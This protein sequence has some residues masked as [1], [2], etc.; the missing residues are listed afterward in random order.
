MIESSPGA[1]YIATMDTE[2]A[3]ITGRDFLISC[4][5]G[6]MGIIF[7]TA[8]TQRNLTYDG[9]AF[10]AH[11]GESPR[12]AHLHHPMLGY[13]LFAFVRVGAMVSVAPV[14]AGQLFAAVFGGLAIAAFHALLLRHAVTRLCA[15]IYAAL[16]GL[17]MIVMEN[18][19]S[20]ELYTP[21]LVAIVLSLHAVRSV[22]LSPTGW[23]R[24]LVWL[25]CMA[26][27][28]MHVGFSLWVFAIYVALAIESRNWL[29]GTVW[30]LHGA[31]VLA[32]L[33]LWL[34]LEGHL[35]HGVFEEREGFFQTFGRLDSTA[36]ALLI[37]LETPLMYFGRYAG[38]TIFPAAIGLA[39]FWR[40]R[41]VEFSLAVI[42]TFILWIVF[43]FWACDY[44]SFFI[45]LLP[46]WGLAS[47]LTVDALMRRWGRRC[48]MLLI[49][50][51]FVHAYVFM[52]LPMQYPDEIEFEGI[53]VLFAVGFWVVGAALV[54]LSKKVLSTTE[55]NG[56]ADAGRHTRPLLHFGFSAVM[57]SLLAYA[58]RMIELKKPDPETLL[59]ED[60]RSIAPPQA[61]LVT[62]YSKFRPQV[63]TGRETL[64]AVEGWDNWTTMAEHRKILTR[65]IREMAKDSDRRLFLD[66]R[67]FQ[68]RE[69]VFGNA[70]TGNRTEIGLD[71][72]TFTSVR[73]TGQP[74]FEVRFVDEA[75][76]ELVGRGLDLYDPEN[77]ANE[78]VRWT[79]RSALVRF[80]SSQRYMHVKYWV[81]HEDI[82]AAHPL[83]ARIFLD[84]DLK[85][86]VTHIAR[87]AYVTTIDL[88]GAAAGKHE[89]L[90]DFS[91]TWRSPDGRELGV[92]LY[93]L[94]FSDQP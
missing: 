54:L 78:A 55:S 84:N 66:F 91:R 40:A 56:S 70:A 68:Q 62:H 19:T 34:F 53:L 3:R 6:L 50:A 59:Y 85:V 43:S 18:A 87:D 90:F 36:S 33:M 88:G 60:F 81:G 67:I 76:R 4:A 72:L 29:R 92:G 35:N 69:F 17:N 51:L 5:L 20:V 11:F 32:G 52:V 10:L 63:Q 74:L 30:L 26:V 2:P 83:V 93:P 31:L 12:P 13:L 86:E 58:P 1:D 15:G 23:N 22:T 8:L 89:L 44:G 14:L 80:E 47:A 64:S 71:R 7:F 21:T 79:Q 46:I 61:R 37:L 28:G 42:S 94:E 48:L 27:V 16:L 39:F 9:A 73:A 82:S 65:W 38:V 75:D 45:P 49:S 57:L 77:W 25:T 41:H 24:A